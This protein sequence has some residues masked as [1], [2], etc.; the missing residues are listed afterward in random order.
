MQRGSGI[1]IECAGRQLDAIVAL[2]RVA[3]LVDDELDA[4]DGDAGSRGGARPGDVDAGAGGGGR[5]D[6]FG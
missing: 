3:G 1:E 2:G 6:G 5:V 4:V